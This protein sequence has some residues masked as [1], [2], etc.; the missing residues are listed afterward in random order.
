M[1][2]AVVTPGE[3]KNLEVAP[4]RGARSFTNILTNFTQNDERGERSA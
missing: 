1:G 3:L 2:V 4:D